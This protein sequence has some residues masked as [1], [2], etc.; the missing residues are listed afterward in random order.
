MSIIKN[1][2][3]VTIIELIDIFGKSRATIV[4]YINI[5]RKKELIERIGSKKTGYWKIK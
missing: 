3:A 5:L 1:N 4:R 2:N